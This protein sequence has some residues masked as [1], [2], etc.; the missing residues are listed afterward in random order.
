MGAD[1]VRRRADLIVNADQDKTR[2]RRLVAISDNIAAWLTPHARKSGT[3]W[4]HGHDYLYESQRAVA[5]KAGV[6]GNR[7]RC[8]TA[9]SATAWRW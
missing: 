2:S 7:T 3:V 8:A 5:R 4:P 1:S 9:S 6:N